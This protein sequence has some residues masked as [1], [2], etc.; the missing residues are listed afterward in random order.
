VT[1]R[2]TK[3]YKEISY[4]LDDSDDSDEEDMEVKQQ[5]SVVLEKRTRRGNNNAG[6][7]EERSDGDRKKH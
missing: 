3:E 2:V 5:E 7:G 1:D 4:T 6:E